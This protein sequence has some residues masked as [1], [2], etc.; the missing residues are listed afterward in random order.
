MLECKD[1]L[2]IDNQSKFLDVK[3]S[4][5]NYYDEIDEIDVPVNI[6]VM[7]YIL[8]G[9]IGMHEWSFDTFYI[10]K[11]FINISAGILNYSKNIFI[12]RLN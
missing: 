3:N 9:E 11:R 5:K 2:C 4:N 7:P 12:I 6:L 8:Y 1:N 10:L